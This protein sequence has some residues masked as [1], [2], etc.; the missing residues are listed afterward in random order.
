[1]LD[2]GMGLLSMDAMSG[3]SSTFDRNQVTSLQFRPSTNGH[4]FQAKEIE[5]KEEHLW[6]ELR[7]N[8]HLWNE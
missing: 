7:K 4:H 5:E 2:I 3:E 6:N 8:E 1:M